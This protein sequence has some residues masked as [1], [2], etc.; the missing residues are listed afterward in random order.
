MSTIWQECVQRLE[1]ELTEQDFNT[2][3]R[4]LQ[5]EERRGLLLLSVPNQ[6]LLQQIRKRFLAQIEHYAQTFT[7]ECAGIKLQLSPPRSR[8]PSISETPA[9]EAPRTRLHERHSSPLNPSFTFENF[10][11]GPSNRLAHTAAQHGV[12]HAGLYNP[13]LFYGGVGLGKT[14][15]MQAVGQ[16]MLAR[17]PRLQICYLHCERFVQGLV[18]ALRSRG[19]DLNGFKDYFRNV[20]ALL[21]DDIPFLS[22]KAKSQEE[23]L[24]IF[25]ALAAQGRQIVITSSEAPQ[26]LTGINE[27]LKSRLLGGVNNAIES[28]DAETRTRILQAKAALRNIELPNDVA[29]FL[30]EHITGSVRDLES[31]LARLHIHTS[32]TGQPLDTVSAKTALRDLMPLRDRRVSASTIKTACAK[33]FDITLEDLESKRRTRAVVYPRQIAMALCHELTKLSLTSI[34]EAFGRRDHS[35]VIYSQKLIRTALDQSD[36]PTME[37]Y[38]QI[39]RTLLN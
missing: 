31:A 32:A 13:L 27:Q 2:Y 1:T 26:R 7:G 29:Q 6:V 28:P 12:E 33:Y 18:N 30:G 34:G 35:T 24:Y 39:K 15:L 10:V 9:A 36:E 14:H 20:D 16:Q 23:F 5:A 21:I 22:G 19:G 17:D 37:D 4:P 25:D 11:C 38:H 3:V 8:A